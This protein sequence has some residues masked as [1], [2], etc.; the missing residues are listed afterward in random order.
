MVGRLQAEIKQT[1]PFRSRE[2]E[3]FISLQRTADTLMRGLTETLKPAGLSAT[4]YN[5]LRILRG[6]GKRGLA[7]SEIAE[8]LITRDPDITR[9]LD[10][11]N[12]RRLIRRSREKKDRRVITTRITE[13][14]LKLLEQLDAPI[15][16]LHQQQLEHLGKQRVG[17]LLGLLQQARDK[18]A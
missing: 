7:C 12:G 4:Q 10:R 3:L 13:E 6:A 18:R 9:L 5:V 15:A 14:G 8:R 2:E 1:K 17:S 11:L 16:E